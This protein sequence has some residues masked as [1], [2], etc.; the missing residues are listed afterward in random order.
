LLLKVQ[1]NN[2]ICSEE[3]T[4]IDVYAFAIIL[5][6]M[7][8]CT[9]AWKGMGISDIVSAVGRCQRPLFDGLERSM[10]TNDLKALIENCWADNP[11][12]RYSFQEIFRAIEI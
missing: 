4:K 7:A 8:G 6:E 1:Q 9:V 3:D 5:Y 12:I 2:R 10:I 11:A